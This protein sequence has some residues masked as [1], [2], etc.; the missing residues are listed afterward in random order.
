[1]HLFNG[2]D[3]YCYVDMFNTELINL[4]LN[5]IILH[6]YYKLHTYVQNRIDNFRAI[7]HHFACAL[8]YYN[9]FP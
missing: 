1:M 6:V 8:F 4:Q 2:Q 7:L 3:E 5:C 9:H